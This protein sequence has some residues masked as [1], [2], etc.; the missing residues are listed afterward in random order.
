VG[1][2]EPAIVAVPSG[3]YNQ[4]SQ[5]RIAAAEIAGSLRLERTEPNLMKLLANPQADVNG[6]SAAA[7]T[8]AIFDSAAGIKALTAI[9]QDGGADQALR[10]KVAEGLGQSKQAAASTALDAALRAAPENSQAKLASALAAG[11]DGAERLLQSI[12]E[13]KVTP[14]VLQDKA[15]RERLAAARVSDLDA[16]LVKLTQGLPALDQKILDTIQSRRGAFLAAAPAAQAGA[17]VFEK[18]CLACHKLEGKGN[19]IGPNLDGIGARG[20]D[21]ILEDVLDP[22]RNIDPAFRTSLVRLNDGKVFVGLQ[23]REEGE[24]LIFADNTGK[25]IPVPKKDID[26]RQESKQS[27]MPANFAETI[28][29]ADFNNL[30]AFLLSKR[31]APAATHP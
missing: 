24:V 16:R 5:R 30:L 6:R 17:K 22:S 18:N 19:I 2:F 8:L 9:L 3:D 13:G 21:R 4:L 31:A 20:L 12:S 11:H 27:L 26:E 7:K 1:R 14:R 23:R 28:S 10:E 29:A 25:E 15:L